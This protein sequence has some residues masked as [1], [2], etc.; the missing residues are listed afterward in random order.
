MKC[1]AY[2]SNF[3]MSTLVS[4]VGVHGFVTKGSK[5]ALI[6]GLVVG[7]LYATSAGLMDNGM[8]SNGLILSSI[9]SAALAWRMGDYVIKSKEFMPRGIV[10]ISALACG[11][12]NIHQWYVGDA[13]PKAD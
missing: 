3:A 10:A 7:G 5:P 1:P 9:T 2:Y 12:Y 8:R 11:M 6:I 13:S 4:A